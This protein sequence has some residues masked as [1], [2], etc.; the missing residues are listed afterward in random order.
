M[1][2]EFKLLL[3]AL[4]QAVANKPFEIPEDVDWQLFLRLTNAH[5]VGALAYYGLQNKP[6]PQ[7]IRNALSTA[8]HL[9]IYRDS[10]LEYR[11]AGL[12]EALTKANIPHIFLKGAV[13][14]HSYPIPALRTMCD[15]D[16]LVYTKDY[17][18]IDEIAKHFGGN[19]GH[20]DG[21][22][23]N[24]SFPE[25]VTVEFHPNLLHQA[26]PV[27]TRINPGWQYAENNT[28]TPE[29]TYLNTICHLANHFVSGGVGVRFVLDVW[30]NRHLHKPAFDKEFV[31]HELAEFGLLVFAKHIE[32]LS[33]YW[34]GNG[35]KTPLLQELGQ[36]IL[37]SGSHGTTDRAI[38]NALSLSP[39]GNRASALWKKA[40]YPRQELEDRFPWCKGKPLL[41]PAAWCVRAY[42][43]VT[44]HGGLIA[45]WR[46]TSKDF[47]K[48]D[49]Q[50][51]R[52]K[53]KRFGIRDK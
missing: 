49:I 47:T 2:N 3:G 24:Y 14:K 27:G 20:S 9:A 36:Y 12:E 38:L 23:K 26:T 40:F 25:G 5:N 39:G 21:N 19:A 13:L 41:L 45:K 18:A 53:L 52:D 35:E 34:F 30:V 37:T 32:Q 48:E 42:N 7:D 43:A 44:Q 1:K 50:T 22:H 29:G 28:L 4:A 31:D 15:L 46:K 6:I 17:P 33:D 10:Q 16:I 8:F 11:K 51:Q